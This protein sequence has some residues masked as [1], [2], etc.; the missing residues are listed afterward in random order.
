MTL[1][2]ELQ[3]VHKMERDDEAAENMRL[4]CAL[5]A[6]IRACIDRIEG[7]HIILKHAND[8]ERVKEYVERQHLG[9]FAY[10]CVTDA[11]KP[12]R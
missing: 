11:A 3:A 2:E 5:P 4:M 6:K 8:Y 10:G 1:R 9:L 7:R 12:K